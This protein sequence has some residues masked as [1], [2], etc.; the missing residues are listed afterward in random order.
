MRS[1]SA[2]MISATP[3]WVNNAHKSKK[4]FAEWFTKH[5]PVIE[6]Y[7]QYRIWNEWNNLLWY[8]DEILDYIEGVRTVTDFTGFKD[9]Q[10]RTI[11]FWV[12]L[13][14]DLIDK[15]SND[16]A[17]LKANFEVTPP[18]ENITE[19]TRTAARDRKSVV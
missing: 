2:G 9:Q 10:R 4:K 1:L 14:S 15:R 11:P 8:T 3:L 12:S 17:S 19:Q 5:L 6:A 13:I 7:N 16:L 18:S